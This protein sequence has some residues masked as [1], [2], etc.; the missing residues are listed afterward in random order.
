MKFNSMKITNLKK[1]YISIKDLQSY[2]S[3]TVPP[4]NPALEGFIGYGF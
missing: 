2:H 4:A 1:N 3:K